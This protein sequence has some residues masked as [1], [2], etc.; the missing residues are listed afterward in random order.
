MTQITIKRKQM[1]LTQKELAQLLGVANSTLN[2]WETGTRRPS[3]DML[4]RLAEVLGCTP[5]DLL[6]IERESGEGGE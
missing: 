5:N 3:I 2:Q 6:G 1:N 4:V